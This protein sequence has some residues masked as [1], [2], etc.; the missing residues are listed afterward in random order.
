MHCRRKP[1]D[2]YRRPRDSGR[3]RPDDQATRPLDTSDTSG[4]SAHRDQVGR[5]RGCLLHDDRCETTAI[6]GRALPCLR[7]CC[8]WGL[9]CLQ[10]LERNMQASR[11]VDARHSRRMRMQQRHQDEQ[12]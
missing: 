9:G 2:L 6:R 1:F 12:R 7:D 5:P 8:R 4:R 11:V 3:E 10:S